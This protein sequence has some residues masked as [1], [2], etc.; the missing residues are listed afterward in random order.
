MNL[1]LF[2]MKSSLFL[3]AG[4]LAEGEIKS[5]LC[6]KEVKQKIDWKQKTDWL[7]KVEFLLGKKTQTNLKYQ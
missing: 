1:S 3:T 5:S 7:I 4:S 6:D 2:R